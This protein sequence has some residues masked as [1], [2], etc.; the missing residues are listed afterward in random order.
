MRAWSMFEPRSMNIQGYHSADNG[1]IHLVLAESLGLTGGSIGRNKQTNLPEEGSGRKEDEPP[2]GGSGEEEKTSGGSAPGKQ[3]TAAPATYLQECE[4]EFANLHT[5]VT[6]L[7]PYFNFV[8]CSRRVLGMGERDGNKRNQ[9]FR[10]SR[11]LLLG[12]EK[13]DVP[14]P[15]LPKQLSSEYKEFFAKPS[16]KTE[17]NETSFFSETPVSTANSLLETS[18][19][20]QENSFP[21]YLGE[22]PARKTHFLWADARIGIGA[23]GEMQQMLSSPTQLLH[24]E[25]E[26]GSGSKSPSSH[27]AALLEMRARHVQS[28]EAG[29]AGPVHDDADTSAS[30]ETT[31]LGLSMEAPNS[32]QDLRNLR[33]PGMRAIIFPKSLA[34]SPDPDE[35][36]GTPESTRAVAPF[37]HGVKNE[38]WYFTKYWPKGAHCEEEDH[39]R[40]AGNGRGVAEKEP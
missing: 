8:A 5:K 34:F 1:A 39:A 38:D 17:H 20:R 32:E 6:D 35:V 23:D 31:R 37:R 15:E 9:R 40:A 24:R 30:L 26:H 18:T 22:T 11:G 3:A 25:Q 13:E 7:D 29:G 19:T 16:K 33:I 27:T 4:Q 28:L 2:K 14:E 36:C 21:Y 10:E 12:A